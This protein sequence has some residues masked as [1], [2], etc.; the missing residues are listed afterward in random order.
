MYDQDPLEMK[1]E[2]SNFEMPS[3]IQKDL[4]HLKLI[5]ERLAADYTNLI[6]L[7]RDYVLSSNFDMVQVVMNVINK[8]M[9]LIHSI[10]MHLINYST[11][12]ALAQQ[13]PRSAIEKD[14]YVQLESLKQMSTIIYHELENYELNRLEMSQSLQQVA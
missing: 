13:T 10:E 9:T 8:C 11:Y 14:I 12:F 4:C 1:L 7:K 5:K 3:T 6:F 2:T